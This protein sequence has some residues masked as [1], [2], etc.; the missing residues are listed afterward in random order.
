MAL[1]LL[2]LASILAF[3]PLVSAATSVEECTLQCPVTEE[4]CSADADQAIL[5]GRSG[6]LG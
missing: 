3:V 5:D 1:I 4:S 2:L 6:G